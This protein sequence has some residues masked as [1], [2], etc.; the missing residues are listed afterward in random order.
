MSLGYYET[1]GLARQAGAKLGQGMVYSGVVRW[2]SKLDV[3]REAVSESIHSDNAGQHETLEGLCLL[4]VRRSWG[5]RYL[6]LFSD[7]EHLSPI[8]KHLV[9]HCS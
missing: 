1:Q 3:W 4:W 7:F 5:G 2:W 9:V 8:T 6:H